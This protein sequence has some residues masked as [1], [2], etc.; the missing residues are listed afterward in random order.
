LLKDLI[1]EGIYNSAVGAVPIEKLTEVRLRLGMPVAV[2]DEERRYLLAPRATR[3][4]IDFTI[5]RAT[6]FSLYAYQDEIAAGF[7]H[8]KG[9][10]RVGLAGRG[11]AEGGKILTFKDV[12]SINIRIP[13]EILGCSEPL[14]DIL[15]NFENTLVVAPPFAGKTTLIRDLARVLS[16]TRDVAIIDEREEIAG[17]GAYRLGK[18]ADV[19]SGIPKSLAAEGIIRAMSPE[20]IILDELYPARDIETVRDIVR[21]GVKL[22]ASLH[23]DSFERLSKSFPELFSLFSYGV[24]LSYKPRV[25]SIKSVVRFK[26]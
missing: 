26:S 19:I 14:K 23:G 10:I 9:G 1:G 7:I 4:D 8:C 11:V 18:L 25:G 5:S 15:N 24:L 3:A 21:S 6:N 22:V 13:H 2:R 16:E 17:L 12:S 20:I